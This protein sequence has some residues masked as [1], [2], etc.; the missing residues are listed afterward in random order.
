M[1]L[2]AI[3][4]NCMRLRSSTIVLGNV[5]AAVTCA[6]IT[7]I[8]IIPYE[9][10]DTTKDFVPDRRYKLRDGRARETRGARHGAA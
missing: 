3:M 9:T 1:V 4:P 8:G 5:Y 6:C 7:L 2:A 10:Q